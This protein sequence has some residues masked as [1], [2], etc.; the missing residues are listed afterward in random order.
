[1]DS[2]NQT[3]TLCSANTYL[4]MNVHLDKRREIVSRSTF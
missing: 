3:S 2:K 1:M 4:S